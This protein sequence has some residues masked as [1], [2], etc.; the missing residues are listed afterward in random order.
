MLV[1]D[2]DFRVA[3]RQK[4]KELAGKRAEALNSIPAGC[5]PA[6]DRRH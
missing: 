5:S 4:W 1:A 3:A 6:L 2:E